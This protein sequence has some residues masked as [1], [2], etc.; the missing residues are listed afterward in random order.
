MQVPPFA[1]YI[2]LQNAASL[3]R[4]APIHAR[5]GLPPAAK[6]LSDGA[7]TLPA[8]KHDAF[9][10]DVRQ[11]QSRGTLSEYVDHIDHI[12]RRIGWE[13]VGIGTDFNHGSGIIGFDGEAD[14]PNVT[15][16]LVRRGYGEAQIAAIWGGNFLRVLRAPQAARAK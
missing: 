15:A 2:H 13:H 8:A 10:A 12:A 11:A 1:F 16:E 7:D 5:Y 6:F 14:A 4:I 3:A 9:V